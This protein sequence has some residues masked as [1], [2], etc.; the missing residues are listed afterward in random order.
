M[1]ARCSLKC[2]KYCELLV[3]LILIAIISHVS[4]LVLTDVSAALRLSN[5]VPMTSS[6][7]IVIWS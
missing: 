5:L 6:F 3:G 4:L 2:V 7:S 1:F